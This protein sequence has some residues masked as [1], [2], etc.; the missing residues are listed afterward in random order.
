MNFINYSI[1]QFERVE[2]VESLESL[3]K[4]LIN[5]CDMLGYYPSKLDDGPLMTQS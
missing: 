5:Y 4:E 1:E 3:F 2:L